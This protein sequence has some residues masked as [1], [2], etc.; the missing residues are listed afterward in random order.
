M[1]PELNLGPL[2]A[3]GLLPPSVKKYHVRQDQETTSPVI[4]RKIRAG[5]GAQDRLRGH[6][7]RPSLF[8]RENRL[9]S[10]FWNYPQRERADIPLPCCLPIKGKL[11]ISCF[12]VPFPQ[13]ILQ[14]ADL[15]PFNF[16]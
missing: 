4:E 12:Y 14:E 11:V 13:H 3:R 1:K 2:A 10:I 7:F 5:P 8:P 9:G 16:S 15:M 6:C